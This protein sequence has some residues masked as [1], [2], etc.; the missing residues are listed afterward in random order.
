LN[1]E[2]L[3]LF[4]IHWNHVLIGGTDYG[5]SKTNNAHQEGNTDD[6]LG[7]HLLIFVAVHL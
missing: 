4:V 2:K 5:A 6:D 7:A 3:L 1:I